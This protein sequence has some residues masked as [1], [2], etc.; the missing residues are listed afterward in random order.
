[1]E[2]EMDGIPRIATGLAG[3]VGSHGEVCG[4]LTGGVLVIGL[5][6]GNDIPDDEVKYA[7]YAKASQFVERFKQVNTDFRCRD[8]LQ[9]DLTSDPDFETYKALNLREK[10]CNGVIHNAVSSLFDLLQEWG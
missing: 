1:M 5:L 9:I 6:H 10:V 8:L 3:G 2:I 4:A 7:C